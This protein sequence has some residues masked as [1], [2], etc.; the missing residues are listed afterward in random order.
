MSNC[1][2]MID[3][4]K[5]GGDFHS[6]TALVMYPE[7][8]KELDSGEV[9]LEWDFSKG[10]PTAPLLKEKFSLERKKAKQ[11]NFSLAYGKTAS[12]FARDW[13][14][15]VEEAQDT[16][17]LWYK[18]RHEVRA[19]QD[20]MKKIAGKKGWCQTLL[21]RYRN[22]IHANASLAAINTPIQGGAA[23]VII[24]AMVKLQQ[25]SVLRDLGFKLLLQVHDE[26]I[27]E[28][29]EAKADEALQRT[30]GIMQRPLEQP[31]LID[32]E[33]DAKVAGNWFD[34]K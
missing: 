3:A 13:E 8:Q 2:G 10:E 16:V 5:L 21:G 25:D 31:L 20:K 7:I 26:V 4:F 30:I 24:G 34:A 28:G 9:L 29:P 17:N 1:T 15:S 27:L 22:L 14:C 6:R 33:V 23:D 12:G 32:L 11:M 18:D 19:W